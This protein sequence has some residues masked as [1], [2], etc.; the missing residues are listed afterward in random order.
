MHQVRVCF[1]T[2][3]PLSPC[4]SGAGV[5][6]SFTC[7]PKERPTFQFFYVCMYLEKPPTVDHRG[8]SPHTPGLDMNESHPQQRR[9]SQPWD[10][11]S[12]DKTKHLLLYNMWAY[13]GHFQTISGRWI[14]LGIVPSRAR[15]RC[16]PLG[17]G[18]QPAII[19]YSKWMHNHK[20]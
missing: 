9:T 18:Y 6:P 8:L 7:P 4:R 17:V 3:M 1:W 13:C 10:C 19:M 14:G 20:H 16:S 5:K 15:A 11:R 2:G 12:P